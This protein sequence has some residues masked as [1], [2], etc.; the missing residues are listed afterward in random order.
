MCDNVA[1][2]WSWNDTND[3]FSYSV[4]IFDLIYYYDFTFRLDKD[5][6]NRS[7]QYGVKKLEMEGK[8]WLIASSSTL[9]LVH[10]FFDDAW[11]QDESGV[12]QINEYVRLFNRLL[13]KA[14]R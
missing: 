8:C 5:M 9:F 12:M 2:K 4:L 1:W 13:D 11:D 7:K 10:I 14:I 6:Y 3:R